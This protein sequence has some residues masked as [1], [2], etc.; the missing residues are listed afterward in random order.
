MDG[1]LGGGRRGPRGPPIQLLTMRVWVLPLPVCP[2]AARSRARTGGTHGT[3]AGLWHTVQL[4]EASVRAPSPPHPLASPHWPVLSSP[5]VQGVISVPCRGRPLPPS[6]PSRGQA[7]SSPGSLQQHGTAG[8][9]QAARP[10][11]ARNGHQ[12]R[13]AASP[14]PTYPPASPHH[15]LP[16]MCPPGP[17][18]PSPPTPYRGWFHCIHPGPPAR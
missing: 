15:P 10:P 8:R 5:S 18:S 13:A 2:Y 16:R 6:P 1:A 3:G 12:P 17:S 11:T 14:S 9:H 7:T 4:T